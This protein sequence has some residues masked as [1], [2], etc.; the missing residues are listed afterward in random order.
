MDSREKEIYYFASDFHLGI[1]TDSDNREREE[2]IIEW[3][4]SLNKESG[5]L[6]LLGDIFD[7]W[8][9]YKTV[10]PKGYA[11]FLG[12]LAQLRDVGMPIEVFTGNHDMWMF[13][14]FEKELDIPVH[15]S[16]I[17]RTLHGKSLEIGHGDG[18]GPGDKT[19]K[20][21]K[22]VFASPI[23]QALFGWIHPD[24]GIKIARTWSHSSRNGHDD[25]GFNAETEFI[26][27][28][29][30]KELSEGADI[31]YFIFGHRHL[32]I[33]YILSN[34]SSRYINLG[35]WMNHHTYAVL[36]NGEL[37]LKTFQ[38][39]VHIHRNR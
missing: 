18:L 8:Y 20:F 9:E 28:H 7:F 33:D 35:E 15:K 31:D 17:H 19:Y 1:S 32:P 4:D 10:I 21:I 6:F 2:H 37:T 38:G 29:C 25:E 14:Y 5:A 36:E 22:S 30:E 23:A 39:D 27:Q 11:R 12:K 26:L 3:L 13:G 24:I 16:R 34:G